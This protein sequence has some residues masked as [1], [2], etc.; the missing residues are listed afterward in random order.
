[1]VEGDAKGILVAAKLGAMEFTGGVL[2]AQQHGHPQLADLWSKRRLKALGKFLHR[3]SL[4]NA[5]QWRARALANCAILVKKLSKLLD[6]I[7]F[8]LCISLY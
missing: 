5:D 2:G 8:S 4:L 3:R 7:S 1:M 6:R